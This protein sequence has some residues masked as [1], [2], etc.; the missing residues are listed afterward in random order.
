MT[1]QATDRT[2]HVYIDIAR[3]A[4]KG[5]FGDSTRAAQVQCLL[6]CT[7]FLLAWFNLVTVTELEIAGVKLSVNLK[8][9]AG[10]A[11]AYGFYQ[12]VRFLLEASLELELYELESK[13]IKA[14]AAEAINEEKQAQE[15]RIDAFY[16]RI[17][18]F[19]RKID[20]NRAF[21][22]RRDAE[23]AAIEA[24]HRP[25]ID[26]LKAKADADGP[27]DTAA[28]TG[29]EALARSRERADAYSEWGEAEDDLRALLKPIWDQPTPH[30]DMSEGGDLV[31]RSLQVY[32]MPTT[33]LIISAMKASRRRGFIVALIDMLLPPALFLI[34]L[35]V[36]LMIR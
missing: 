16:A 34:C 2:G 29:A 11:L 10:L 8:V 36:L 6:A 30:P 13:P 20:D 1:D 7:V 35:G 4:V 31:V 12:L 23:I 28:L 18:A 21:H 32:D 26:A 15:A 3:H 33:E 24:V 22:E 14:M 17:D 9:I 19:K 27:I 25:A 5:P